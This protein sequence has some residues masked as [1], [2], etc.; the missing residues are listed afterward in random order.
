MNNSMNG[1]CTCGSIKQVVQ[2]APSIRTNMNVYIYIYNCNV[3]IHTM[4]SNELF[5]MNDILYT[6]IY[7][8]CYISNTNV[9]SICAHRRNINTQVDISN[10][11]MYMYTDT[12]SHPKCER[13]HSQKGFFAQSHCHTQQQVADC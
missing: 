13:I 9:R 1:K 2:Y 8:L 4:Y 10:N 5:F 6:C 11:N 12:V 7:I 3:C